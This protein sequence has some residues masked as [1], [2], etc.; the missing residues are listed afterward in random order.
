MSFSGIKRLVLSQST[1]FSFSLYFTCSRLES[2]KSLFRKKYLRH[3]F[4]L[5]TLLL[6]IWNKVSQLKKS[7]ISSC[8]FPYFVLD[9]CCCEVPL[10]N[11]LELW[12]SKFWL[13][14][15]L[16]FIF[17]ILWAQAYLSFSLLQWSVDIQRDSLHSSGDGF[18][19]QYLFSRKTF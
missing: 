12:K 4:L 9:S 7:P 1:L 6:K 8:C 5:T 3:V 10:Q 11:N 15:C 2:E 13:L 17:C 18:C 14:K 16:I 19:L